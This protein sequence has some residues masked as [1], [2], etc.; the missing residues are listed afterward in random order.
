MCCCSHRVRSVASFVR[1]CQRCRNVGLVGGV[2]TSCGR[3]RPAPSLM[4]A[5]S[6]ADADARLRIRRTT[7][8]S[9]REGAGLRPGLVPDT[10]RRTRSAF[11]LPRSRSGTFKLSKDAAVRGESDSGATPESAGGGD[12]RRTSTRATRPASS[13][14]GRGPPRRCRQR[15]RLPR[16]GPIVQPSLPSIPGRPRSLRT[17]RALRSC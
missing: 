14:C 3:A 17:S 8:W 2:W 16:L 15:G 11:A 7:H 4:A 9:T 1:S 10:V 6:D 12:L 13:S 5:W